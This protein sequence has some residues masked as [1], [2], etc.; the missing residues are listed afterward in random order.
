MA[1]AST[2]WSIGSH[3]TLLKAIGVASG[4][5]GL[6][7]LVSLYE[8]AT[9]AVTGLMTF[10][11]CVLIATAIEAILLRH[12]AFGSPE[13]P[14]LSTVFPQIDTDILGTVCLV[15]LIAVAT[16]TGPVQMRNRWI[17]VL[18]AGV[19]FIELYETRTRTAMVLAGILLC[20]AAFAWAH[21]SAIAV[22][23]IS[24]IAAAG[25]LF[26]AL[27]GQAVSS[28]FYRQQTPTAL[29]TL[30]GRTSEWSYA[31]TL[32]KSSPTIGLGYYSGFREGLPSQLGKNAASNLDETW[33]ETLVDIGVVG[34]GA[35]VIFAVAGMA[36]L[37]RYRRLLP[38]NVRWCVL[39][40]AI[41]LF[42]VT[43][44]VNPTIQSNISP[45]FIIWGFLL[46]VFPPRQIPDHVLRGRANRDRDAAL[47]SISY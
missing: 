44:F 32:W 16:N 13:M 4:Y 28:Y 17:R 6:L 34:C 43:S 21:R 12:R 9:S 23:A 2:A 18:L 1:L 33:L 31:V 35:L 15:G 26:F 25:V 40:V 22:P 27:G 46:L 47:S 11:H 41:V 45:N 36:R 42:P 8:N 20:L 3:A 7:L 30:T 19:Y 38:S 37:V 29:S 14:R 24:L 10:V 5:L 39:A